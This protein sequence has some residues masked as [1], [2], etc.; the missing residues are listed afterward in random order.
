MLSEPVPQADAVPAT[1]PDTAV[2]TEAPAVEVT[3]AATVAET[4]APVT[5]PVAQA[6]P[7]AE[8]QPVVAA[9]PRAAPAVA[10]PAQPPSMIRVGRSQAVSEQAR[11]LREALAL[12]RAGEYEAAAIHYL[13]VLNEQP[14]AMDALLGMGAIAMAQ[15]DAARAVEYFAR[16]LRLDPQNETANAALIG[17]QRG[18][19][20][21]ASE[22]AV[23]TLLQASP[24]N[25]FLHFTLGNIYAL[26]QR[27]AEAQQAFFDAYRFDSA[28]PDYA[29]NLAASLDRL[30]QAQPALDYYTVALRLAEGRSARFDAASVQ[31]RVQALSAAQGGDS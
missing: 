8:S 5:E 9:V 18:A 27:W 26:Q 20:P 6:A 25:P 23:K 30:G 10:A 13:A 16:V 3:A 22:S 14:Q 12:Y 17:L 11:M 31:A 24:E 15:G 4:P 19:D 1:V 2:A 29:L 7:V 21:V 28:N